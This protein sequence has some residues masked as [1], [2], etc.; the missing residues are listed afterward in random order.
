MAACSAATLTRLARSA[1][2]KPGVARAM[3]ARSRSELPEGWG[4]GDVAK[5]MLLHDVHFWLAACASLPPV[6]TV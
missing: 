6:G 4:S 1:P 3:T 5:V 2:E